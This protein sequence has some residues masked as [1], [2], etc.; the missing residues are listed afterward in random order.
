MNNQEMPSKIYLTVISAAVVGSLLYYIKTVR[1]ERTKREKIEAWRLMN[2]DAIAGSRDRLMRVCTD[3]S[4][5]LVE[6]AQV[7]NEEN[8]FL[9]LIK[10]QPM[11]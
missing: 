9:E 5:S 11:C 8:Q 4:I 7:W 3:P 2:L 6:L 10:N 1:E